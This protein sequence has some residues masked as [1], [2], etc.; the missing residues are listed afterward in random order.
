MQKT[1]RPSLYSGLT[2]HIYNQGNNRENI[3]K[4]ERNYEYFLRKYRQF[5]SPIA[6]TYAYCF[7]AKSFPHLT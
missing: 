4:E 5:I 7:I 1:K 2:Y 3:F 6:D